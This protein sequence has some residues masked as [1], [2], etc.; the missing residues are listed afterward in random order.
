M[1]LRMAETH[2]ELMRTLAA[3]S[4]LGGRRRR[5]EMG[6]ILLVARNDHATNPSLLVADVL[7]PED[8]DFDR[9]E[10][11]ALS[12]SSQYLRRALLAIR[13]QGLAGFLTVHTHPFSDTT[14]RF[15]DYDDCNDPELMENLYDLQPEGVFGSAV[16]GKS[17]IEAR[18][19]SSDLQSSGLEE[20]V[21]IGSS[22]QVFPLDGSSEKDRTQPSAIFDRGLAL[23]GAGALYK[24]SRMRFGVVGISGTGSLMAELLLRAGA[25]EIVCFEFDVIDETNLNRILHSRRVDADTRVT[26]AARMREV[27][28]ETGLPTRITIIDGG[29]IRNADVADELR[30]CDVLLGCVDREWPRQILSE[31]VFQYLVPLIDMGAEIGISAD[32]QELQSLDAR[33]SLVTPGN[34][35]LACVGLVTSEGLR[36]EGLSDEELDRTLALGYCKDFRLS[37]PAVMDLNMRAASYAMLL[38]RHLLQ[39]YMATPLPTSIRESLTSYTIKPRFECASAD[40]SV[41]ALPARLGSGSRFRLSVR[42]S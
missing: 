6:C 2:Y 8:G 10:H 4:F 19:W 25:G 23:S 17:S 13:A 12:F 36:L 29:D 41:C 3:P 42:R 16:L 22:Y 37:A 33:V 15:S 40:C 30:G 31:V 28:G 21:V 38:L 27:I 24:M 18:T 14:V 5:H 35:C 39:P 32:G 9:Q 20:L 26:K 11:S 34:P 1:K 7:M